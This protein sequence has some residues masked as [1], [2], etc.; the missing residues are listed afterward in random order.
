MGLGSCVVFIW[1]HIFGD[2]AEFVVKFIVNPSGMSPFQQVKNQP[3]R[4][5]N[6]T[7]F[8]FAQGMVYNVPPEV[9][10]K[11]AVRYMKNFELH[12]DFPRPTKI[13]GYEQLDGEIDSANTEE[14]IF[15]LFY[16][17]DIPNSKGRLIAF[18]DDSG[19]S[20]AN[21]YSTPLDSISW[22]KIKDGVDDG[23]YYQAAA[24]LFQVSGGDD[25]PYLYM[26]NGTDLVKTDGSNVYDVG[27]SAPGS[28][29]SASAGSAGDINGTTKIAVS[30]DYGEF[31]ESNLGPSTSITVSDKEIDLSSIPTGGSNVTKRHIWRTDERT[32]A[33]EASET[34][35]LAQT[36]DDN[37][38]TTATLTEA[39][40]VLIAS[41]IEP[42]DNSVPPKA[43]VVERYAE[44]MWYAGGKIEDGR[45]YYSKQFL[46][47][48]IKK[49][50][51]T[52]KSTHIDDVGAQD[53]NDIVAMSGGERQLFIFTNKSVWVLKG[54][55]FQNWKLRKVHE[56]GTYSPRTVKMING[57]VY[58]LGSDFK[59][60]YRTNGRKLERV[61]AG[62]EAFFRTIDP[63]WAKR[64]YAWVNPL[65]GE[66]KVACRETGGNGGGAVG[67]S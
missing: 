4:E 21:I 65:T 29:P 30:Y 13:N 7:Q 39:G 10:R 66:Y 18:R 58:F 53:G 49:P 37:V 40:E 43:S 28:S 26:G 56:I 14:L 59:G 5:S 34:F 24:W 67:G 16:L 6:R 47:D 41:D 42:E 22:S 62:N 15:N 44:R 27:N 3:N 31:G 32:Y 19:D 35:Y 23:A 54:R 52:S 57:S 48:V 36:I 33:G 25:Q 11:D 20:D 50:S 9:A 61:T 1:R 8:S 60:I 45:I 38:T 2:L 51:N 12:S 63:T 17:R 64:Y 55:S 46:P